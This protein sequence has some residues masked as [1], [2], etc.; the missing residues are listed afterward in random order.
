V[1]NLW[2]SLYHVPRISRRFS[3]AE[4]MAT[5]PVCSAADDTSVST[6]C[7]APFQTLGQLGQPIHRPV[8][9]TGQE[10]WEAS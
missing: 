1:R 8:L 5:E 2:L 6:P 7:P 3:A 9:Q 4:G 10:Q